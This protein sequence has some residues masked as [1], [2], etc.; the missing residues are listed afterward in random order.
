MNYI[1]L[2]VPPALHNRNII[3][4][5]ISICLKKEN[6]FSKIVKCRKI[7]QIGINIVNNML[8]CILAI[9]SSFTFQCLITYNPYLPC[10]NES[11][12]FCALLEFIHLEKLKAHFNMSVSICSIRPISGF[13]V[14]NT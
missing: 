7:I 6:T 2:G 11:S 9:L 14:D 3:S 13:K 4:K 5:T 8:R 10:I 12:K 1:R